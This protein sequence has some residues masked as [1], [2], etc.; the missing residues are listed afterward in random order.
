MYQYMKFRWVNKFVDLLTYGIHDIS[1]QKKKKEVFH[2]AYHKKKVRIKIKKLKFNKC[3]Y[4]HV[5]ALGCI[6]ILMNH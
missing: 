3:M 2:S 1:F 5:S 4:M 6:K